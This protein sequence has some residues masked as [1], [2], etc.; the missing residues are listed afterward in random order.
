MSLILAIGTAIVGIFFIRLSQLLPSFRRKQKIKVKRNNGQR[1][2]LRTL[3]IWGSGN[4]RK[5][6]CLVKSI[7]V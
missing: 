5:E 2:Q 7:V 1:K 3:V 4:A 6:K